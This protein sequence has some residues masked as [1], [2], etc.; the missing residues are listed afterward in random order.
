MSKKEKQETLQMIIWVNLAIGIYNLF[1]FTSMSSY[2]HLAL[3][4]LNIGVWV[5]NRHK[6]TLLK[7]HW[8][9]N[10]KIGNK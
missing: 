10:K 8:P 1:I 4:I 2:F 7:I 5:F 9:I 6:L 3:G